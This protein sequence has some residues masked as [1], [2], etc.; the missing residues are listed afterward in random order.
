MSLNAIDLGVPE[1]LRQLIERQLSRLDPLRIDLLE[2]ASVAGAEFAAQTIETAV[3]MNVE[4]V[5]G[6]CD[7]PTLSLSRLWKTQR[8]APQARNALRAIYE[9]FTE[10][11]DTPDLRATRG[12]LESL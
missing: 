7:D 6:L 11:F 3:G 1:S 8:R 4:A 10:G 12:L 5:E 9:S 2:C